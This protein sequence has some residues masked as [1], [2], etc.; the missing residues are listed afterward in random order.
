MCCINVNSNKE[1]QLTVNIPWDNINKNG[2]NKKILMVTL[3]NKNCHS[4]LY[5]ILRFFLLLSLGKEYHPIRLNLMLHIR[6]F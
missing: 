6:P 4:E 2:T 5:I 1:Q 3:Q